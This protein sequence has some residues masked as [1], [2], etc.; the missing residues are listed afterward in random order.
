M[1]GQNQN[2]QSNRLHPRGGRCL[3][4]DAIASPSSCQWV[5]EWVSQ[6]VIHN[7]RFAIYIGLV[8]LVS[9]VSPVGTVETVSPV[10][11]VG[12]VDTVETVGTVG[13]VGPV[14][15]VLLILQF[16]L[17]LLAVLVNLAIQL[18][19]IQLSIASTELCELVSFKIQTLILREP[20]FI[21]L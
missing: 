8:S 3:F 14:A 15:L 20:F 9:P 16:W 21:P 11:T 6:S 19:A 13:P 2:K 7:F 18:F 5:S 17:T 4:L 10:G 12:T 1:N